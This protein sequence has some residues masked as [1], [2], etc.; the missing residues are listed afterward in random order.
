LFQLF[1]IIAHSP[2]NRANL[3]LFVTALGM[4]SEIKSGRS[5]FNL[6]SRFTRIDG[7]FKNRISLL[8]CILSASIFL[9]SCS[10]PEQI[11]K[12]R[13][14]TLQQFST[15][16][17]KHI[18]DRNPQTVMES[19]TVLTRDELSQPTTDKLQAQGH[20]PKTSI[21]ILKI[22]SEQE[23]AKR[24]NVVDVSSAKALGPVEKP[25]IPM[26]VDG[27]ITNKTEGKPDE[28]TPFTLKLTCKFD[29]QTGGLPQAID[30]TVGS[31]Q[32]AKAAS[33]EPAKTKKKRKRK[34]H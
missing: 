15:S 7:M 9:V 6:F 3:L 11:K 23:D 13:L 22:Q 28:S 29:E 4:P 34:R 10:N 25:V 17:A 16:V 5:W 2:H 31:T 20:I 24:T 33:E 30:A 12:E 1:Q 26:Q 19:M 27:T 32:P 21:G 8:L 14:K 18:F